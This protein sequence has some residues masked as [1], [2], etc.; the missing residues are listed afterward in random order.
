MSVKVSFGWRG[1]SLSGLW[2]ELLLPVCWV[3]TRQGGA[4][5]VWR[6]G[7][8]E[9]TRPAGRGGVRGRPADRS[10]ARPSAAADLR[11]R[12]SPGSWALGGRPEVAVDLAGDVSLQAADDLILRQAL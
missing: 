12:P 11:A 4:A 3:R 2:R 10:K 1:W 8:Y 5:P 6:A 9:V 7:S